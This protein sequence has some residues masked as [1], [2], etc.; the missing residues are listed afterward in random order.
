M[1]TL[2][3]QIS[4]LGIV[5]SL[6]LLVSKKWVAEYFHNPVLVR[7]IAIVWSYP[8][9]VMCETIFESFQIVQNRL[10]PV[11]IINVIKSAGWIFTVL[12]VVEL[13]L[14]LSFLLG[15]I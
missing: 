4:L 12:T 15:M 8:F 2:V 7:Y 5:A 14:S 1:T 9:F 6:F 13:G 11:F 3:A 10:K